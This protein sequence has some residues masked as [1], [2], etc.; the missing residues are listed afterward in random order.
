MR[1]V[2]VAGMSARSRASLVELLGL[3]LVVGGIAALW[4]PLAL[5]VAGVLLV[6]KAQILAHAESAASESSEGEEST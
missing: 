1:G 5:V 6:V 2:R 3:A 4:W